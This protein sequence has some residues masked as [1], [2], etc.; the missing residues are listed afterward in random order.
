MRRADPI[1]PQELEILV[2]MESGRW[3]TPLEVGGHSN[4][5]HS[6]SLAR[7]TQMGYVDREQRN[8]PDC[9]RPSYKYKRTARGT[10]L[11]NAT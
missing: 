9:S 7:L 6:R 2:E 11:V 3:H 5:H 1:K 4:S 8:L 10:R